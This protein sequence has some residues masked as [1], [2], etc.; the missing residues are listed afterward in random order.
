MTNDNVEL[1]RNAYDA[2]A[3]GDL[4]AMLDSIDPDLEWTYLDPSLKRPRPQVCH[5]RH[6]LESILT[7]WAEHGFTVAIEEIAGHGDRVMVVVQTPGSSALLERRG[8]D[9]AYN[10]LTVRD[11]RIVAMHDCRN[12]Q[13]A[14]ELA[15]LR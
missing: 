5:G 11:G 4:P 12:R 8:D 9:R 7:G 13:E 2:F 14:I 6:E 3:R 10:V 1:V 15:G